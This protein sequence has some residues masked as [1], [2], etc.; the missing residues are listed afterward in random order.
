MGKFSSL[1]IV[2]YG[3]FRT[4][5]GRRGRRGANFYTARRDRVFGWKRIVLRLDG[6][7]GGAGGCENSRETFFPPGTSLCTAHPCSFPSLQRNIALRNHE[8]S[9]SLPLARAAGRSFW[10][11]RNVAPLDLQR[12]GRR[13]HR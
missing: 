13:G 9:A 8:Q 11:A 3:G 1:R 4:S 10:R 2:E 12:E 5:G 6:C 7:N